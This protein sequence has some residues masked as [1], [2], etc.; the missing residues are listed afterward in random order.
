MC[1]ICNSSLDLWKWRAEDVKSGL[2]VICAPQVHT[3]KRK[4][5]KEK[6]WV[7]D[8]CSS[9]QSLAFPKG[10]QLALSEVPSKHSLGERSLGPLSRGSVD[11][12]VPSSALCQSLLPRV[13]LQPLHSQ[14]PPPIS[15]KEMPRAAHCPAIW[16]PLWW[17][18]P[19]LSQCPRD[20]K[21]EKC[22]EMAPEP[23]RWLRTPPE[24]KGYIS[25]SA[26]P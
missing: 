4:E 13:P 21:L 22:A 2:V 25:W 11:V 1:A 12:T 15:S 3:P 20:S 8:P 9:I 18:T 26:Q 7:L 19:Q 17:T 5:T 16:K 6:T 10:H 23:H 14:E 24:A